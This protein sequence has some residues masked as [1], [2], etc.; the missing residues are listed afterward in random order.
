MSAQVRLVDG[1]EAL[2]QVRWHADRLPASWSEHVATARPWRA[3]AEAPSDA[4]LVAGIRLPPQEWLSAL[5]EQL[6]EAS[7]R[8]VR[9]VERTLQGLLLGLQ[10]LQDVLPA[11]LGDVAAYV[12]FQPP[13]NSTTPEWSAVISSRWTPGDLSPSVASAVDNVLLFAANALAAQANG[14]S[15]DAVQTVRSQPLGDGWL[16]WLAGRAGG[17]PA[18]WA[19]PGG[20]TLGTSPEVVSRQVSAA[21]A[22][23]DASPRAMPDLSEAQWFLWADLRRLRTVPL[24]VM[25]SLAA[26]DRE[27][28]QTAVLELVLWFDAL[29]VSGTW[30][31]DEWRLHATATVERASP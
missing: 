20:V 2:L 29:T 19:G 31:R 10:P 27:P 7:R 3:L 28:K 11:V 22:A 24:Y 13:A 30:A 1:V 26:R 9:R 15:S 5:I 17:V 6:P 21:A 12:Q 4:L 18:Y 8:D 14:Q 23:K 25:A 16:R